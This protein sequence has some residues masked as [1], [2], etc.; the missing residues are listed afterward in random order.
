[1]PLTFSNNGIGNF[2]LSNISGTGN[3]LFNVTTAV[4]TSVTGSPWQQI[5]TIISY[6][7]GYVT[8]FRNPRF[9]VYRLDSGNA[10]SITDGGNDMFD[11]GNATIPWLRSN[12]AYWNPGTT[13]YAGAPALSYAIQT[14]SLT[15]TNLYYAAFGYTASSGTFPSGL[16]SSIYHPLTL[17]SARSGSGPIGW[18]KSGNIGADGF[19]SILTGSIYT[20][21]VI[22]GFTTYA[23]FRQTYGQAA[24]PNICDVYML[25]G[26]PNWNSSFGTIVWNASLSTQGQGAALYASGSTSNLLAITTLLSQTGS[27]AGGASLPI[28]SSDIATVVNNFALRIQQA[29]SY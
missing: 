27:T 28:S 13:T 5:N 9:F 1:M 26:H 19:G 21:S 15:D 22:N 12:T 24:D 2:S 4:T 23:Y 11:G 25:F 7:R 10:F 3:L 6:L 16:Q 8:D 18:Q 17:I 20:G 14:S 29:L